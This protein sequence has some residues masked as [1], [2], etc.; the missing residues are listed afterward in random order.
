[1]TICRGLASA[2]CFNTPFARDGPESAFLADRRASSSRKR[3]EPL[4]S[5]LDNSALGLGTGQFCTWRLRRPERGYEGRGCA[6]LRRKLRSWR[7]G[8]AIAGSGALRCRDLAGV[9]AAVSPR[10]Q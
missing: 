10:A 7:G 6:S 8:A 9:T 3:I 5:E 4:G 2:R 1:M